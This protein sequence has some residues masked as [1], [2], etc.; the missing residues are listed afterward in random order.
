ME[1]IAARREGNPALLDGLAN[2]ARL[3]SESIAVSM[4]QL[5]RVFTEAKK[6]VRHG[7]WTEWVRSNAGMSERSAQQF[8]QVYARFGQMP[9]IVGVE[10][11]KVFKMLSLPAGSEDDFLRDNDVADMTSREVEEAVRRKQ[12]ELDAERKAREAAE[13]RAEALANRAPEIPSDIEETLK[14]KNDEIALYK[15]EVERI[16]GIAKDLV[17]ERDSY[18]KEALQAKRDLAEAEDM[19]AEKQSEYDRIQAELLNTQSALAK[20]DA[21]R[22]V[23]DALTVEDFA[24]AVRQFIGTCARMPHMGNS[25]A[26]MHNNERM[27]FTELLC[28][29]EGWAR[30]ARRALET[31]AGE[32]I[33]V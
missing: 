9:A 3:Y 6:L 8:M 12:A 17:S 10:K 16:S 25:F 31:V 30:D 11:S 7:E 29:V 28:T 1:D 19:L 21:E 4:F 18:S 26:V 13:A 23:H 24:C 5:G 22:V 14:A 2:E 33:E 32:V 27:A 15:T 20:G